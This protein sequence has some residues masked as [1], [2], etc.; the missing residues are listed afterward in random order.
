[1]TLPDSV[2]QTRRRWVPD[3]AV[4]EQPIAPDFDRGQQHQ[5]V[6]AD[7]QARGSRLSRVLQLFPQERNASLQEQVE[8]LDGDDERVLLDGRSVA[9]LQLG[10]CQARRVVR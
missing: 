1:M 10:V 3:A 5:H 6:L 2:I 7:H 8:H 4:A 9:R